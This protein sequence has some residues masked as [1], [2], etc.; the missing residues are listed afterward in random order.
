MFNRRRQ[1]PSLMKGLLNLLALVSDPQTAR[2]HL[3]Q[4]A[5][6]TDELR[7]SISEHWRAKAELDAAKT[8]QVE[9][10]ARARRDHEAGLAKLQSEHAVRCN[11]REVGLN[12]TAAVLDKRESEVALRESTVADLQADLEQRL[13]RIKSAMAPRLVA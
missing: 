2:G 4:I 9:T 5:K 3:E 8:E 6:A 11:A 12:A 10:L 13:E 7:S 1:S